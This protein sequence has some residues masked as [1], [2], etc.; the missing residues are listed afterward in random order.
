MPIYKSHAE[1][2]KPIGWKSVKEDVLQPVGSDITPLPHMAVTLFKAPVMT[3]IKY[4]T[5]FCLFLVTPQTVAG[6]KLLRQ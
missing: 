1:G 6:Q 2:K 5:S 3:R 4:L